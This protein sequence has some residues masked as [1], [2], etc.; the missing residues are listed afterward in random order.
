[1][2]N[3]TFERSK[4][5]YI[6]EEKLDDLYYSQFL[7]EL[8][9]I[10]VNKIKEFIDIYYPNPTFTELVEI[11]EITSMLRKLAPDKDGNVVG[12]SEKDHD[13][14]KYRHNRMWGKER[15]V[16][17]ISGKGGGPI[18][19]SDMSDEQ[20]EFEVKSKLSAIAKAINKANKSDED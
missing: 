5:S 4:Y 10:P 12:L 7:R 15:Q 16:I 3:Q 11:R 19:I 18:T 1:M 8:Y 2:G 20:L 17:E 6:S 13:M 9:S 14:L